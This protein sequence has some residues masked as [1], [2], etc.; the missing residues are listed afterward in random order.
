MS[1]QIGKKN[2]NRKKIFQMLTIKIPQYQLLSFLIH[3]KI[4]MLKVGDGNKGMVNIQDVPIKKTV[5]FRTMS[6]NI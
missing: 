4:K 2:K 6:K 5:T 3:V 1:C